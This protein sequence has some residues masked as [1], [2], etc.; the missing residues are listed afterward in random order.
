MLKKHIIV[1]IIM[2]LFSSVEKNKNNSSLISIFCIQKYK[3]VKNKEANLF[4]N[5]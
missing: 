2:C 3:N 4:T 1:N 5:K